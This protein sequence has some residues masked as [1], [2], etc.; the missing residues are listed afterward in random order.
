MG[1]CLTCSNW[2]LDTCE[3]TQEFKTMND[4]CDKFKLDTRFTW[5][6]FYTDAFGVEQV[7]DVFQKKKEATDS[8]DY[9][10]RFNYN[11]IRV[12]NLKE[13]AK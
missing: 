11:N 6:L 7:F 12:E 5:A 3:L 8:I 13:D 2:N 9:L 1:S 10:K 4:A